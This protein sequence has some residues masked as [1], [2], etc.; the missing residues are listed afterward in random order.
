[1]KVEANSRELTAP[2]RTVSTLRRAIVLIFCLTACAIRAEGPDEK[3]A[4]SE[5]AQVTAVRAGKGLPDLNPQFAA[6][7]R[8]IDELG[9]EIE[10][11]HAGRLV[12]VDLA[13]DRVS[14]AD[15]DVYH[16]LALP[17][18]K[19]LK[20]SGGGVT[21][22]GIGLISSIAGLVELSLLDA[23]I[24]DAGLG[25]LAGLP[26]LSSLVIRRS[27]LLSDK[28]LE[29]LKRL[30][31]L[32]HLGLLELA[33]TDRGVEPLAALTRLTLLDLRGSAQVGNPGLK[34]LRP[35]KNLRTLRLGG[36][37]IDDDSL[38][39]VADFASLRGL[40]IDEAAVTDAGLARLAGLPLEDFGLIRCYGV[41]DEGLRPLARLRALRQLT[42]RGIPLSG[43]GLVHL[44]G[45]G[46]AGCAAAQRDGR[47]RRR[48]Q[49]PRWLERPHPA[50]VA[51]N[52]RHRRRPGTSQAT[53][54]SAD[55]GRP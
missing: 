44:R 40:T 51:A 46:G 13:G 36:S 22:K 55:V 25:Q 16:L 33:V 32:T 20:L 5:K 48:P 7:L 24:D 34:H 14:V 53:H 42:V 30:P 31:K 52:A 50:G 45:L 54:P 39:I 19:S 29:H 11:D 43:A 47:G 26:N 37:Q 9:G 12:G 18:L 41:T 15:A 35:L 4:S 49:E 23:Q 1:M 3:T 27:P 10:F 6:A 17:H 28:G 38:A 21:D 2:G 8:R